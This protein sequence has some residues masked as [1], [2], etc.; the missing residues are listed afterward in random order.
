MDKYK[1]LREVIGVLDEI[2]RMIRRLITKLED[3]INRK[4]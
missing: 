3:R 2:G 1:E 4:A